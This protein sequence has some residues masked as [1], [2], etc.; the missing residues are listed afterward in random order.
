M[1]LPSL[2]TRLRL[3]SQ[4]RRRPSGF[5]LVEL[6]LVLTI[7][8][9]LMGAA[10]YQLNK[11]G[12]FEQAVDQTIESDFKTMGTA[13]EAYRGAAG[14]FPT[15][16]QG[17]EALIE[18]PTKDPIPDRWYK[19]FEEGEVPKDPWKQPYKYRYPATKSKK[20]Y[21]IYS[22]GKDGQDGTEDDV[23]NWKPAETK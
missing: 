20:S 6:V 2:R 15:T 5:T 7:L 4:H 17:L 14:R 19:Y 22:I 10:I 21:D 23:G 3:L 13:L 16:E 1:K 11:S 9:V 12:F 8:A 18:K